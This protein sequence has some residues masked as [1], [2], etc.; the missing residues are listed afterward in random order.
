MKFFKTIK[1]NLATC[2]F[3]RN[4]TRTFLVTRFLGIAIGISLILS[5]IL[6]AVYEANNATAY[7]NSAYSFATAIGMVLSF[8]DTS[9]KTVQIFELVDSYEHAA[10]EGKYYCH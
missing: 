4:P 8:I 7:V 2:F 6:F 9:L 5:I 10:K 1:K 3:Y